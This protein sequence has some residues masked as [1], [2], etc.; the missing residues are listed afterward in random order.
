MERL[1]DGGR[2]PEGAAADYPR[3]SHTAENIASVLGMSLQTLLTHFLLLL[4]F[5]LFSRSEW[6]PA[7]ITL[8][9]YVVT[10]IV[11]APG[12]PVHENDEQ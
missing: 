11:N 3:G 5:G 2:V 6:G 10:L 8:S 7:L 9:V 12:G 4:S 1:Q